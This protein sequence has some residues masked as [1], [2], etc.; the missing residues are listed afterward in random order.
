M[1]LTAIQAAEFT[2]MSVRSVNPICLKIRVRLAKF[3]EGQNLFPGEIEIDESY[4]GSKHVRSKRSRGA[5]RKTQGYYE[6]ACEAD[7]NNVQIIGNFTR[8]YVR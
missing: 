1:D 8:N 6:R 2:G 3:C 5:G 7:P 4:F